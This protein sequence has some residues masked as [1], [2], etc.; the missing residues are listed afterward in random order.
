[1]ANKRKLKKQIRYICGDVAA[2]CILAKHFIPGID[3]E[4]INEALSRVAAL[5]ETALSRANAIFD[6]VPRDFANEGEYRKARNEY[7]NKAF[8]SLNKGFE[9]ELEVIVK[10]M[11]GAMPKK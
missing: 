8:K 6:K 9:A 5:Q 10:E 4:K 3:K 7:Y 1:M 11:N 2:A